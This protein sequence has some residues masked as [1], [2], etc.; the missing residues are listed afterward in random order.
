[1][2]VGTG[3]QTSRFGPFRYPNKGTGKTVLPPSPALCPGPSMFLRY[4]RAAQRLL[5]E[6][7]SLCHED[8][9]VVLT[10]KRFKRTLARQAA[11]RLRRAAVGVTAG[12]DPQLPTVSVSNLSTES[13]AAVEASPYRNCRASS[14]VSTCRLADFRIDNSNGICVQ[15]SIARYG[16]QF[17]VNSATI[18]RA[19]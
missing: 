7:Y 14:G 3:S 13:V 16:C 11:L 18:R 19:L 5:G 8:G 6:S 17:L 12:L 15:W 10:C 9:P 4:A 1:M 2:S